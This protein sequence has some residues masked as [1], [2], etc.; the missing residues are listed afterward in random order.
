[1]ITTA[2]ARIL[3]FGD[4][5]TWGAIPGSKERYAATDRWTGRLQTEL[6]QTFDIVEEGLNG[7]TTDVDYADRPGRNGKTYLLPCLQSQNPLR[8]VVLMLGTNDIKT[9]FN[10]TATDIAAAIQDLVDD[11]RAYGRT[12][13]GQVPHILLVSPVPVNPEAPIFKEK[14]T[15]HMNNQSVETSVLLA[16]EI[17][18]TAQAADCSFFDAATVG[19]T[20]TDG[21]HLTRESHAALGV[22]IAAVVKEWK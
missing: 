13:E 20:G 18:K 1:M 16:E 2:G 22:V 11:I 4:S 17:K 21:V 14:Y 5:N 10:R 3:C 9:D 15:I 8:G 6:G 12:Q 7:R 19:R